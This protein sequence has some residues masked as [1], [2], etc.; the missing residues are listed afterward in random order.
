MLNTFSRASLLACAVAVS[1]SAQTPTA[2][3]E[4][5]QVMLSFGSFDPAI[6]VPAV[7]EHLRSTS[8][9]QLC[10][11]QFAG[12][13][14]QDGRNAV[15]ELGGQIIKYMPHDTYVV[16]MGSAERQA[17]RAL[18]M[19]R[20][21]GNYHPAY[22]L[23]PA[24]RD[25]AVFQDLK[26]VTYNVVVAD[27]HNDKPALGAKIKAVGGTVV[28]EQ[29]GSILMTVR[30]NGPQLQEASGFDEV[31]W[32]DRWSAPEIDMD[33]ARIQGGGNSVETLAGYTGAGVNAHIYEGI[34]ASHPD[35]TGT[36]TNVRSGGGADSHGHAT[37]GIVFGNGN[38]NIGNGN[39]D[40]GP[41]LVMA[42]PG[43]LW[44]GLA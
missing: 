44:R 9:Q 13:P 29:V 14:T 34:E 20:W 22:R 4:S 1:L 18:P 30:L 41:A 5:R 6:S 15:V 19:V 8:T 23:E 33:N 36:V 21:V 37:A 35:F 11:V 24:L 32:I 26:P 3:G 25:A 40:N 17:V 38:S 31:L 7:P 2:T 12:V 43:L 39:C 42:W 16:R 28:S 10:L 27:K